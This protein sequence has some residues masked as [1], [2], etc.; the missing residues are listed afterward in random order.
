MNTTNKRRQ[1]AKKCVICGGEVTLVAEPGRIAMHN[2]VRLEIPADVAIPTCINCGERFYDQETA[3]RVDK[4]L[5][6]AL[7]AL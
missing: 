4:A 1:I 6:S 7:E 2:G 5:E 3:A